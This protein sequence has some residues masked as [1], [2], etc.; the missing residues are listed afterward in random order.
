MIHYLIEVKIQPAMEKYQ[1]VISHALKFIN[2]SFADPD[3]SLNLVAEEAAL[4]PSHFST[5]FSQS[6]GKTFIE[7]LT[8]Q[9]IHLAKTFLMT[10][11]KRLSEI[12]NEVGYNDPNYFSF[13]FKKKQEVSPKKYREKA[14]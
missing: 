2:D 11:N 12:A 14:G 3:M 5:I 10:A 8:D 6:L 7:Y 1:S 4:S 9:R 13:L